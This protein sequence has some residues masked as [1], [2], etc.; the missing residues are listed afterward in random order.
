[1]SPSSAFETYTKVAA[2]LGVTRPGI[3]RL[4]A[5]RIIDSAPAK[6]VALI[7]RLLPA[8][9]YGSPLGRAAYNEGSVAGET[10]RAARPR[11]ALKTGQAVACRR[12][13]PPC[14]LESSVRLADQ[15]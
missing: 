10:S 12:V 11:H 6:S 2:R 8:G 1:M 15:W 3:T 4:G 9:G 5:A 7:V 14:R 13:G